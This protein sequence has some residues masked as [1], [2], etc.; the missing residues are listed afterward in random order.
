MQCTALLI[1]AA[2]LDGPAPP[3][4]SATEAAST[5]PAATQPAMTAPV[6]AGYIVFVSTRDGDA[7]LFRMLPDGGA[8]TQL[9]INRELLDTSPACSPDGTRIAFVSDREGR[10]AI[11]IMK[12]D[13][14]EAAKVTEFG[15]AENT[16]ITWSPDGGR[17][18]YH[19]GEPS[20]IF[21]CNVDGSEARE[22]AREAMWPAWSPDGKCIL[23]NRGQIPQL[24]IM[25]ADGGKQRRFLKTR[26]GF[27][28][29]L[30]GLWSP[31]GKRVMY[32]TMAVPKPGADAGKQMT[33]ETHF[34]AA[35]GS[36]DP[37]SPTIDGYAAGW[38]PDGT[39]VLVWKG[40]RD[41]AQLHVVTLDK[42]AEAGAKLPVDQKMSGAVSW[43]RP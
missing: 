18:A 24:S 40:S 11:F 43:G 14:G 6:A 4:P 13:G 20:C 35:D 25:D 10:P 3:A 27:G 26:R 39:R 1:L 28:P 17:L 16:R 41:N 7:E 29:T 9:T 38:S 37:A 42:S 32:S 5:P 22:I 23:F 19:G 12:A 31:D 34:A 21:T 8:L 33:Y 2:S 36:D 15:V 30:A